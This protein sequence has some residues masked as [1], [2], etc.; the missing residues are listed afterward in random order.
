MFLFGMIY[1]FIL[2]NFI[3]TIFR[4]RDCILGQMGENTREIG[5]R[6]KLTG[7]GYL[8]GVMVVGS[9]I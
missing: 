7:L 6:M 9:L 3:I 1:L 2:D 8:H 5:Y 4:E